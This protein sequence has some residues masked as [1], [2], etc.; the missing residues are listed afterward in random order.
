M[1]RANSLFQSPAQQ[2]VNHVRLESRHNAI[3]GSYILNPELPGA[4]IA[5]HPCRHHRDRFPSGRK[6]RSALHKDMSPPNASFTTRHG[7]ISLNIATAGDNDTV[8]KS[9]VQVASRHGK[10]NVNIFQIQPN[11]H[12]NLEVFTRHGNITVFIPPNFNGVLNLHSRKGVVTFLDGFSR[13]ARVVNG[14][15][16]E[17]LVLFGSE[18]LSLADLGSPNVDTCW[19]STRS[20]KLTIGVSGV[21]H[22]DDAQNTNMLVKKL[23]SFTTKMWG[24][25]VSKLS[26]KLLGTD[27]TR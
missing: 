7:S 17:A 12:V 23:D 26:V 10:C 25:D 15:D 3:S 9:H 14:N 18:N 8:T 13:L 22:V 5:P 21:D 4:P 6:H 27:I 2:Q 1:P 16:Y 24:T 19:L 20:G 11:K